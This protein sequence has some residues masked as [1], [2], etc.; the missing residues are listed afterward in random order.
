MSHSIFSKLKFPEEIFKFADT[1]FS[2]GKCVGKYQNIIVS[3]PILAAAEAGQAKTGD[4][5]ALT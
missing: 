2:V 5:P 3:N 1:G 4:I